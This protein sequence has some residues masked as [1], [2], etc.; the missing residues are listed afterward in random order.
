MIAIMM[1]NDEITKE[2][3]EI[4]AMSHCYVIDLR[5]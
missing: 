4:A 3:S 2:E 1:S 5:T